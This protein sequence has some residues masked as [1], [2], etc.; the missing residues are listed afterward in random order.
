MPK[1]V[2]DNTE[3]GDIQVYKVQMNVSGNNSPRT[4][5]MIY[6]E[7]RTQEGVFPADKEFRKLMKGSWKK[8]FYGYLGKDGRIQICPNMGRPP[9]EE[10]F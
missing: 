3:T 9:Q 2:A 6:N 10:W 8:H 7:S 5:V 1:S 4:D